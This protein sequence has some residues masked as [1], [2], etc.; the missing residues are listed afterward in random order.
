MNKLL[1]LLQG[2]SN[3]AAS[4]ISAPIDGLAWLLRKAGINTDTPVMGSDWMAQ[5]GLTAQPQN[6]NIGLLGEA[7]GG[8]SP[9]LAAAKAPQ[10]ARGLLQ[11][12]DNLA[13]PK[14]LNP[15][16]GS[17]YLP[18]G[19]LSVSLDDAKNLAKKITEMGKQYIPKIEEA[20]GGSVYL[21]VGKGRLTKA[22]ELAKN[23]N[24]ISTEFKARFA[25][26]PSY[27]GSTISS[28]PFTANTVDD[29]FRKFEINQGSKLRLGDKNVTATFQ[30]DGGSGQI[31]SEVF[32]NAISNR[33]NPI[34][35]F[36]RKENNPFTF[37]K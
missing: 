22:G 2:A 10:M 4:N 9:M 24:P 30:P 33:G 19:G 23:I 3:S 37:L 25:D 27:W 12:A 34:Q 7:L 18:E 26:H 35:K 1:D 36:M 11:M 21:T 6:Q 8:V 28:D 31:I 17:I 15:Q 14:T 13:T 29:L 16:A 5:R 32:E 20:H